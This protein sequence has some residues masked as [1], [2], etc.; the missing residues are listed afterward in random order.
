MIL[1]Q[2][3]RGKVGVAVMATGLALMLALAVMPAATASASI[4]SSSICKVYKSEVAQSTKTSTKE[5]KLM[6]SGN[7][8]GIQKYLLS[9]FKT[10]AVTEKEFAS[11]LNGASAQVKAA[12]QVS[13]GMVAK[14]KTV[15]QNS[16]SLTQF[17]TGI[18]AA[19]STPKVTAA[20]K[21]L[22][23]FTTKLC[24]TVTPAT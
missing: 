13:L 3:Q 6:E 15:V 16:T 24:G 2:L 12:A 17:E 18:T 21:V 7:W 1:R 11:V 23:A 10:E 8:K 4:E 20:L 9:T 19:E 14:F 22:D 5:A